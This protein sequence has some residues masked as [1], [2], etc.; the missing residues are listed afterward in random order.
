[1]D[2]TYRDFILDEKPHQLFTSSP[3][4]STP[5]LPSDWDWRSHFIHM[6]SFSKSYCI[7]GSR[8]G[9]IAAS[10]YV[11][12]KVETVLDCLAICAPKHAQIA[13]PPLLS[14]LRP[15]IKETAQALASRQELFKALLPEKWR[16][17][18]QGA[19]FAFVKHPFKGISATDVCRRLASEIG[20]ITL[21]GEFFAPMSGNKEDKPEGI[22]D[23]IR[24]S[25]ANV[26]DERIK[27][28][29]ERLR[30]AEEK[31]GWAMN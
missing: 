5:R 22:D 14:E 10:R 7:P 28:V 25:V 18:S 17:G 20:V 4:Q 30:E 6:F 9:A 16:I 27:Q 11:L 29:C 1:M 3:R 23:W 2:E 31:L 15:F 24:F 26:D 8:L 12:D 21:P 13:M 19:Y